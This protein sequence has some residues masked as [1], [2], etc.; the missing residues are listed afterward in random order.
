MSSLTSFV[1]WSLALALA[2][3]I[4]MVWRGFTQAWLPD[5]LKNSKIAMIERDL[6]TDFPYRVVGRPDQVYR[7]PDG[8]LVPVEN[9]NRDVV[10]VYD[11]DV[12]Q[13][14]LQAWLMRRN[15]LP[16][17]PF[18]FVAVN[19]RKTRRRQAIR[20]SLKQDEECEALI[21][22]HIELIEGRTKPKKSRGGKCKSCGHRAACG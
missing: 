16:T 20:V 12:A 13:L 2:V 9:K 21:A 10:R 17:A 15:G 14:S 1:L 8:Q 11:T 3:W 4:F 19:N 6:K 7:L 18:G 5:E 22:S